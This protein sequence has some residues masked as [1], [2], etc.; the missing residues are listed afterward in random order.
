MRR[1]GELYLIF[2]VLFRLRELYW[3][4]RA[5][6]DLIVCRLYSF[7]NFDDHGK[8]LTKVRTFLHIEADTM[9]HKPGSPV[10]ADF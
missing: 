3:R 1:P 5:R 9:S 7:V 10:R 6:V 8:L 2:A 4:L